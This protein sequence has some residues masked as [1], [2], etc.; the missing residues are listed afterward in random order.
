MRRATPLAFALLLAIVASAAASHPTSAA[1]PATRAESGPGP[2]ATARARRPLSAAGR[3]IVLL[4]DGRSVTAATGRAGRIGIAADHTF[5][6][7][8]HGFSA[9]LS[10]SQLAWLRADPAVDAVVPDEVISLTA[11][12]TP[13]GVRR[14]NTAESRVADLGGSG[15]GVDAD[16]AIVDTGIDKDHEDL[17]V[18]GG[19]SCSTDNPNSWGDPN[20]HGTHVAGIVGARDNGF[21]VVGVAPGVRLWSVRILDPA[22]NGLVSWYVCGLDWITAQRDRDGR[23]MIE[24]VNMSVAKSGEDD[25][26]CGQVNKDAIHRAVCRLVDSGV[27]VVAA[28]GNNGFNAKRL[29][30]ASYNEVI[31]VSALA[32]TDGKA[33]GTGGSLCYSWGTYDRDDTFAD[34]SNYGR[35]VDLIAPG[36]CIYSTLPTTSS[37]AERY[38]YLS[39]TSMAAPHVTGAVAL[40]KASRPDATPSQVRAALRAAGTNDWNLATDPDSVHEPLLD[41]SHIVNLGDFTLDATAGTQHSSLLGAAGGDLNVPVRV[42]R[43]EDFPDPVDVSATVPAPLAAAVEDRQLTGLDGTATRVRVS[44]PA[45]VPSGTY[46]LR[47]TA[48]DGTRNRTSTYPIVVDSRRPTVKAAKLVLYKGGSLGAGVKVHASWSPATDPAGAIRRYQARWRVNGTLGPKISVS[49]SSRSLTRRTKAGEQ[50]SIKVRARD[51]AGNWSPWAESA[52]MTP[53]LLEDTS[54]RL[55]LTPGWRH[56]AGSSYS[57]GTTLF[58]KVRGAKATLGFTGRAV[59]WV[60]ARSAKRG[61]AAVFIDGTRVAVV[62]LRRSSARYRVVLFTRTWTSAGDHTIRIRVRGTAGRPRVDVDAFLVVH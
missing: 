6:H 13:T 45:D 56:A 20:G 7:V 55:Q 52:T 12:S 51:A 16:V 23:P 33:G 9:R 22:G 5:R 37:G 34:F 42:F 2:D 24:A 3:F 50:V 8:V 46:T 25:G 30:P 54:P 47:V 14:V 44:V 58:S 29:R 53:T 61:T 26:S 49:A 60:G 15:P 17:N 19:I 35:D 28:A 4:K 18:A 38:G 41:V 39:G 10:P 27:T 40:Y 21:G 59:A 57:D 32:D 62:D 1:A 36:K 48:T 31:T 43:A 11:Q